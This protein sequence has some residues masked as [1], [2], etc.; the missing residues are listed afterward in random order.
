MADRS[1][2]IFLVII[3]VLP[4]LSFVFWKDSAPATT[5]QWVTDPE[6]HLELSI[7]THENL[8][9]R[10]S[11]VTSPVN[12][13][14]GFTKTEDRPQVSPTPDLVV[15][16]EE[17]AVRRRRTIGDFGVVDSSNDLVDMPVTINQSD[18]KVMKLT[19]S[20]RCESD[21]EA[22][23]LSASSCVGGQVGV[24]I[25]GFL[26]YCC[27]VLEPFPVFHVTNVFLSNW[28]KVFDEETYYAMGGC[29]LDTQQFVLPNTT[30][31]RI[32]KEAV[33]LLHRWSGNYYHSIVD[34]L[35]VLWR[36]QDLVK[37]RKD[38]PLLVTAPTPLDKMLTLLQ[39][40]ATDIGKVIWVQRDQNLFVGSLYF[41]SKEDC[42]RPVNLDWKH[43]RELF[44]TKTIQNVTGL[45]P[46]PTVP[47]LHILFIK[48]LGTGRAL[49]DYE[50]LEQRV[51][52]IHG[53]DKVQVFNGTESLAQT[54]T[55][56]STATLIVGVHG[57][58]FTNIIFAPSNAIILEIFPDRWQN[59]CFAILCTQ[60]GLEHHEIVG[61]GN[62]YSPLVAD[63]DQI[64]AKLG[65]LATQFLEEKQ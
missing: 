28:S 34:T 32:V 60:I 5:Q 51:R 39:W 1:R 43:L 35:P 37:S 10:P 61:K 59:Q 15:K 40:N 19:E 16:V 11:V 7:L 6:N 62:H 9:I 27:P 25:T 55:L 42:D 30:T 13:T 33:N 12:R 4:V 17:V 22:R 31:V 36:M 53:D 18:L 44:L 41:P 49:V 2:R 64:V 8:S 23:R 45:V 57:A 38:I 24:N 14:F 58:G 54:L 48:R 26:S 50:I 29:P 47:G 63:I 20:T 52:A 21:D 65:Q 46:S 56:F 3:L